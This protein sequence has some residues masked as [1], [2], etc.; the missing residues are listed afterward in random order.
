MGDFLP[1]ALF[2]SSASPDRFPTPFLT[3]STNTVPLLL[4]ALQALADE[5]SGGEYLL[6]E[7]KAI[8]QMPLGTNETVP[9][10]RAARERHYPP[11]RQFATERLRR[12]DSQAGVN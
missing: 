4:T 11:L 3:T 8:L 2:R 9:L 1:H 6:T 5:E 7:I 10:L 12:I